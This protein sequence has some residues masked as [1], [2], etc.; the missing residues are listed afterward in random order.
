MDN[1]VTALVLLLLIGSSSFFQVT[2]TTIK[3]WTSLNFKY[4]QPQTVDLTALGHNKNSPYTYNGR[5]FM[6]T[7]APLFFNESCSVW[8]VT[9][10][11]IK[12]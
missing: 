12:A 4:N 11:P 9:R 8:Q 2:R 7:L 1:V 10:T 5:S 3:T 6:T